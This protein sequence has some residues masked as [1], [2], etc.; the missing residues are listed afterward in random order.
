MP[1]HQFII[2]LVLYLLLLLIALFGLKRVGLI[3]LKLKWLLIFL[4]TLTCYN[5][6]LIFGSML[7]PIK[8]IYPELRWNWGGKLLAIM[9]WVATL[10]L[11]LRFKPGFTPANA[12]FTFK[13]RH[14]SIKPS[15]MVIMI[16]VLFFLFYMLNKGNGTF[17]RQTFWFQA[18]M[19]GLDEE[20][21][22]RG[23]L[24]YLLTLAIPSKHY[25][26]FGAPVNIAGLFLVTYFGFIHG[27]GQTDPW[28]QCLITIL[29]TGL[30]GFLLLW[31]R[32]NTGSLLL[33][34]IAHNL[35]NIVVAQPIKF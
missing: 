34:I 21:M 5:A 27:L 18:T 33:P 13:Q 14:G 28:Y 25:N 2:K 8:L 12:G 4:A 19:P 6:A 7:L 24:L 32:E 10:L 35:I 29:I 17:D 15:L 1:T 3:A 30:I 20:P 31:I 9:F 22:F 26:V 11:L 23:L 16:M